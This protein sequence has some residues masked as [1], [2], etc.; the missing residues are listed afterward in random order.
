MASPTRAE[1]EAQWANGVDAI[2]DM[3]AFADGTLVGLYDTIEQALEGDYTPAGLSAWAG[4]HRAQGSAMIDAFSARTLLD[5]LIYEY[6]KL[7][8][9]PYRNTPEIFGDIYRDMHANSLAVNSRDITFASMAA[10]GGNTGN[11]SLRRLNVDENGY[12]MEGCHIELKTA[13]CVQDGNSGALR[14]AERFDLY[15][16]AAPKD[17]MARQTFGSGRRMTGLASKHAG[18]GPGGSRLQNSSFTIYNSGGTV[19]TK[20]RGWTIANDAANVTSDTTNTYRGHPGDGAVLRAMQL[21]ANE[22]I[23]QKISATGFR[24]NPNLPYQLRVMFNRQVGA[25]D[26]TLTIRL[27]TVT[28]AVVLAAQT[29]WNELILDFDENIWPN[30]FYEDDLDIEIEWSGRTTGT[31]LLDDAWCGPLDFFDGGFWLLMGGS[32]PW[33]IDDKLTGT[34]TGGAAANAKIQYYVWLAGFG[35]LPS[36][37]GGGETWSDP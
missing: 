32:T 15:G 11:G 31:L 20:F 24:L 36:A 26:G 8:G 35:Y 34:D 1:I 17:G 23:S 30:N 25:A 28:K 13:I 29:G 6:G 3:R 7:I 14:H 19:T 18:S 16:T 12:S 10:A 9:S 4:R 22:K 27:G 2:E 37:T 5:P 21:S 33:K